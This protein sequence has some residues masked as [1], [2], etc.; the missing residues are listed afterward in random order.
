MSPS[1]LIDLSRS[2]LIHQK[3]TLSPTQIVKRNP[4][5]LS[6]NHHYRNLQPSTLTF[7]SL[8][9]LAQHLTQFRFDIHRTEEKSKEE[10]F[11]S[12]EGENSSIHLKRV[13]HH[14][15]EIPAR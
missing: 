8:H 10:E 12:E 7:L 3:I 11:R 4:E 15:Q 2:R 6:L 13:H 14:L 5:K 9:Q 1:F